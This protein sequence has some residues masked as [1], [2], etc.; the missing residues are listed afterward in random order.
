MKP[1]NLTPLLLAL[2]APCHAAD[3]AEVAAKGDAIGTNYLFDGNAGI[4][5]GDYNSFNAPPQNGSF[6]RT[7]LLPN[8]GDGGVDISITGLAF[9]L[10]GGAS[11]TDGNV[12]TATITYLGADGVAGGG[13]DVVIGSPTTAT[14]VF[15]TGFD[16]SPAGRYEWQFDSPITGNIDGF[17][18]VFR[19]NL[20]SLEADNAG[21]SYQMRFKTTTGT[22]AATVKIDIAG[23]SSS[24]GFADADNDGINDPFE[25]NTGI[26]VGPADTG[27]DPAK[28]DTD[29][30]GLF[31]GVENNTHTYL[32]ATKTGTS[33]VN[34]DSDNDGL[35]DGV[36]TNTGIFISAGDTGTNPNTRDRDNDR[37]NDSFEV[38][39]GLDPLSNADFD[40]D[41][42]PDNFEVLF[43]GSDPK[44]ILSFPGDG[45]SPAPG[46]FTPLQDSGANGTT[47]PLDIP[48]TLGTAIINEAA[49]GGNVDADFASGVTSFA[50]HFPNI[51]PAAGSAVSI[52][53]FAWPVI[54]VPQ[55]AS[56]D[57]LLQFFDPGADGVV[58]GIDKDTLV[59]TA[60]G[61][62]T[63][64]GATT[65]MYWNFT[66]I[67][68]TSSGT[69]LV[70]KMQ[71]TDSLRIKAQDNLGSGRWV[72]NEG[73]SIFGGK[74][75]SL[76]SIGG[77]AVAQALPRILT[78]T[79][80][81]VTTALTWDLG[82]A[83]KVTLQRSITL[84][85]FTDVPGEIGTT[86]TSYSETSN[87]PKAFF[88]LAIP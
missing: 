83:S 51:F 61:T 20:A 66:P 48:N 59:G 58:D 78:I 15:N 8:P 43:Y 27:T 21:S 47:V 86:H 75:G 49:L 60:K 55:N 45:T 84:G 13:D 19:V 32:S 5:G 46:S 29:D 77:T 12:I 17:N 73:L 34:A 85:S 14:L 70:V 7:W 3:F 56:G 28:Q 41:G 24:V 10:P 62:L 31:D 81:G 36:E 68:F 87:D 33:P 23:T 2:A 4:G 53:G 9:G 37:L 69:A 76:A 6:D 18:S 22:G 64:T 72:S 57:I 67:T 11:N 54:G 40:N 1:R 71:S 16:G 52:T 82:G 63:V 38:N 30:D 35:K 50:L 74:R 26:Y 42:T 65:I 25:T 39:N 88:R 79:R 44:D 80:T